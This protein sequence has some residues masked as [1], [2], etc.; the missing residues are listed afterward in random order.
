VDTLNPLDLIILQAL[1]DGQNLRE[2]AA[3]IARSPKSMKNRMIRIR[4][5]LGAD[6]TGQAIAMALRRSLI[7]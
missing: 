7:E 5:I 4:E 3:S 1:A 6:T 2:I